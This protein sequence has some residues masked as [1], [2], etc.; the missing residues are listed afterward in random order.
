MLHQRYDEC[1]DT[2]GDERMA[3]EAAFRH[4]D[5]D[6]TEWIYYL[7]FFGESSAGL[8]VNNAV[9]KAHYD[10]AVQCKEPGWEELRPVLLLAPRPIGAMMQQWAKDGTTGD[11]EAV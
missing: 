11:S 2:L 7:N 10:Y 6:G 4:T 8:N 9:D 3:F 5:S 1:L